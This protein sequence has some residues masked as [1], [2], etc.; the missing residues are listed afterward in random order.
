VS[1]PT[2]RAVGVGLVLAVLAVL[3][4]AALVVAADASGSPLVLPTP[5]TQPSPTPAVLVSG[6]PRSDGSGPGLVGSPLVVLVGVVGIGIATA[7][8]TALLARAARR[9]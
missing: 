4:A 1:R 8:L 2:A 7:L 3:A 5:G 6:D 9:G